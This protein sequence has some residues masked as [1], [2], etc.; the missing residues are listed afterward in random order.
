MNCFRCKYADKNC[1]EEPC[2]HCSEM[3][4]GEKSRFKRKEDY[5]KAFM[6]FCGLILLADVIFRIIISF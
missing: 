5:S 1:F 6:L 2:R 4:M 3:N